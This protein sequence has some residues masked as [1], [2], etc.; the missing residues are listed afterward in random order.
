[1]G[2]LRSYWAFEGHQLIGVRAFMRWEWKYGEKIYRAVRAVDTA[3]HPGHQGKGIFKK[4]TLQLVDQCRNEGVDFIF[5]TPNASSMPGYLKMGWHS[6]GKMKIH[7]RPV[8]HLGKKSPAFKHTHA[9]RDSVIENIAEH[10]ASPHDYLITAKSA[11][12][13][14]WRY[15]ANPNIQYFQVSDTDCSFVIIF[16]LKPYRLGNEFR[17]VDS[18]LTDTVSIQFLRQHL[19]AAVKASGANLVTFAGAFKPLLAPA[20]AVGPV[21]TL[22]PLNLSKSLPFGFWK[23][24]LGDMEVF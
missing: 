23:P 8:L 22:R 1:L 11:R 16:R 10:T 5:N 13:F 19:R 21:V 9:W 7:F 12:F 17:I 18:A 15:G 6:V 4:L 2:N 24:V 20:F 3:T 14:H